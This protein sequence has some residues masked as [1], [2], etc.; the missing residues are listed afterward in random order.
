M[1]AAAGEPTREQLQPMDTL[2]WLPMQRRYQDNPIWTGYQELS[3]IHCVLRN[4]K[5]RAIIQHFSFNVESV[6]A[7][8]YSCN[9]CRQTWREFLARSTC[10]CYEFLSGDRSPDGYS[11]DDGMGSTNRI[12]Q[13]EENLA[14]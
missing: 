13:C 1:T 3:R 8:N 2:F 10:Q 14:Q 6:G 7:R 4:E 5:A 9:S 11:Y 12:T